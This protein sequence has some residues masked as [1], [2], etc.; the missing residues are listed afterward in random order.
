MS[1]G[2]DSSSILAVA[3]GSGSGR[4]AATQAPLV[5]VAMTFPGYPI[6]DESRYLRSLERWLGVDIIRVRPGPRSPAQIEAEAV[7]YRD[8]PDMPND[9][10]DVVARA[11]PGS[12]VQLN[13]LG[14]DHWFVATP[15][16]VGG[17]FA[18]GRWW[19]AARLLHLMRGT[20]WGD[21]Y[22]ELLAQHLARPHLGAAMSAVGRRS[23][24]RWARAH[25]PQRVAATLD[26]GRYPR[27]PLHLLNSRRL[28]EGALWSAELAQLERRLSVV[29][30]E[31]R[32]PFT[33]TRLV[34][35]ACSLPPTAA[36]TH[37]SRRGLQRLAM[38]GLLPPEVQWRESKADL[39]IFAREE[40]ECA[41]E[42]GELSPVLRANGAGPLWSSIRETRLDEWTDELPELW[43]DLAISL[44]SRRS[45]RHA[46]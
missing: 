10:F 39:T 31:P 43:T 16:G 30:V 8:L 37:G 45:G 40:L 27:V 22:G 44:W 2:I 17:L 13:G 38:T 21:T 5:P 26:P 9:K 6:A 15:W 41:W 35:L 46:R 3:L 23:A 7:R 19:H 1:G 12:R 4:E 11:V 20:G 36:W 32:S 34:E 14:G 29:G 18:R 25:A 33:D 42:A 28:V 24:G